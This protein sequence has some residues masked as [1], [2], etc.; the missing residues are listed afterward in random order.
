MLCEAFCYFPSATVANNR[1]SNETFFDFY[2]QQTQNLVIR[3]NQSLA[4]NQ[5]KLIVPYNS[6]YMIVLYN[7][8]N[9]D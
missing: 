1:K 5:H 6:S 7:S 4:V 3:L 2:D 8:S 9:V